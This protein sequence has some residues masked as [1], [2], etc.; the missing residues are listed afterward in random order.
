M[1]T[2]PANHN[3]GKGRWPTH[4]GKLAHSR[5]NTTRIAVGLSDWAAQGDWRLYF[6]YRDNLEKVTP[7][8]VQRVA[9][10]YLVQNNR[11]GGLFEPTAASSR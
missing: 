8:D 10:A 5:I 9:E 6:L 3:G 1:W 4:T 11:T 2:Q 7:A